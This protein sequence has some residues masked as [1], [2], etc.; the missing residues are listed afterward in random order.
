MARLLAWATVVGPLLVVVSPWLAQTA[1]YGIRD[2]DVETSHRYLQQLSLLHYGE[3]PFWNPY[4]CGGFPAWGFIEGGTIVVSPWLPAYLTLPVRLA[5]RV[6]V[7]GSGLLG[8][9]GA[10]AVAGRFTR[11][12]AGRALVVALWAVDSRWAL[13]AAAGHTWH[14]LYAWMPWCLY[15]FER[16][17]ERRAR[18]RHTLALAVCFA[19]LV[20]GGGIYPLPHVVVTLALYAGALAIAGR[21]LGPIRRLLLPG[22]LGAMLAAPKLLPMLHEFARTPRLVE[23]TE[24]TSAHVLWLAI[25]GREQTLRARLAVLPYGWH[26]YGMYVSLAGIVIL[27]LAV[28]FV[29]GRR[30]TILKGI[31]LLFLVLAMGS[32]GA[33]AP[34]TLV[35][36]HVPFFASQHVPTRFLYPSLLLLAIVAGS[37]LGRLVSR[38]RWL[39]GVGAALVLAL[40][41][42]LATV[43]RQ[44]MVE[45]MRLTAP[46][47]TA[48]ETFHH[49][50]VAPFH[51]KPADFAVPMY[52]SMLGNAGV[53]ECYGVP[54]LDRIGARS[55]TDPGFEG[56]VTVTPHA[57]ARVVEWSPNRAVFALGAVSAG[58]TLVYNMNYDD[59]W[60]SEQGDVLDVDG[61]VGVRLERPAERV[62]LTYRP[63]LLA[64]GIVLGLLGALACLVLGW[65]ERRS[66]ALGS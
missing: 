20:Y 19:L 4:A 43:A 30:E 50:Q 58:S 5:L 49:E 39:D 18:F 52:L 36:A 26:E 7:V 10:Y 55:V 53:I 51:Y 62:T 35:H 14:L 34:W 46:S 25:A 66:R 61:R 2:W 63:R 12:Y 1:T 40:G 45:S 54:L 8:A 32:F 64:P 27:V 16:S 6:E 21:S 13:Q 24:V 37:G 65:R 47:I 9:L 29:W 44:S 3:A 42:D 57:D 60:R 48:G 56:E 41:V 33:A 22:A 17:G 11:S 31:G 59:G 38:R 23:S 28:A 15:F